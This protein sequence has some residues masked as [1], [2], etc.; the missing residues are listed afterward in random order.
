[1][2]SEEKIKK[3]LT[4]VE[5]I[6]WVVIMLSVLF[7]ILVSCGPNGEHGYEYNTKQVDSAK[8]EK[9]LGTLMKLGYIR[10]EHFAEIGYLK[11]TT[12]TVGCWVHKET[13]VV[14]LIH[15]NGYMTP[16]FNPDG[17]IYVKQ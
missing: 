2:A 13:G 8:V 1:M 9:E 15:A 11:G 14:Y 10:T 12:Y 6:T 17:T 7:G 3:R 5:A 16:M 4:I